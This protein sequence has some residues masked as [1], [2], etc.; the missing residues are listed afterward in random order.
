MNHLSKLLF[1]GL[2]LLAEV[3]FAQNN[4]DAIVGTWDANERKVEIYKSGERFIGNPIGP[5]GKRMDKVEILNLEYKDGKWVGKLYA[6]KRDRLLE[7]VCEVKDNKLFLD[8]D[9]GVVSKKAEWTR[10]N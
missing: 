7:V 2:L 5:D 9:G 1:L 3:S 4:Q 10:I 8:V 6:E